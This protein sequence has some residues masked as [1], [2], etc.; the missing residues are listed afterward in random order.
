MVNTHSIQFALVFLAELEVLQ[1]KEHVILLFS[2]Y[3]SKVL[4]RI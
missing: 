3:D 1:K 4:N 2:F